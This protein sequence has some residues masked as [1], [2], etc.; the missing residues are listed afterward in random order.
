MSE[1]RYAVLVA[2]SQ[3]HQE[4][5]LHGLRCPESD[6]DGLNAVLSSEHLGQFTET[7]VLKNR[8]HYEVLLTINQ[9]LKKA[10][11]DDLVLL[12]YSGHGKLDLAG[13]LHL[14]TVDTVIDTLEA[15][16]I[17]VGSIRNFIDVSPSRKVVLILDCCFSGAAGKDFLRGGVDDQL[18]IISGGLQH[19]KHS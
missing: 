11:K 6:V 2:S 19:T 5:R 12:Y 7:W 13:R 15:T 10:E 4:Q 16:S 18:N 17:P 8:P 9:V 3:F 14:A 1:Q